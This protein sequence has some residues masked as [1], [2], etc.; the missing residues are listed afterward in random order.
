M[1][2]PE[3]AEVTP[4]ARFYLETWQT[5]FV[6]RREPM[7]RWIMRRC[8][9]QRADAEDAFQDA[10]MKMYRKLEAL[11]GTR[12]PTFH[13]Y[14]KTILFHSAVDQLR[15]DSRPGA[16]GTGGVAD[17]DP[18]DQVEHKGVIKEFR[19]GCENLH[20]EAKQMAVAWGRGF[21]GDQWDIFSRKSINDE[22]CA[23]IARDLGIPK[24]RVYRTRHR[25]AE[26]VREKYQ[27][28]LTELQATFFENA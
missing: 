4:H 3:V 16:R 5:F 7:I 21:F 1:T 22:D 24:A 26:A 28:L 13:T 18:L 23:T 14:L 6:T 9:I 10:C 25:I 12:E 17:L 15:R 19:A 11:D 8:K 2:H 27:T 20:Q